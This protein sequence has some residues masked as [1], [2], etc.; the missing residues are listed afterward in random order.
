VAVYSP[1]KPEIMG[2]ISGRGNGKKRTPVRT[3]SREKGMAWNATKARKVKTLKE[4]TQASQ[5][6]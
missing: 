4:M 5:S 2:I 3:G 1:K 6:L